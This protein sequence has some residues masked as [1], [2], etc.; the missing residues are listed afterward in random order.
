MQSFASIREIDVDLLKLIIKRERKAAL[1]AHWSAR[2][3]EKEKE[4]KNMQIFQKFLLY[5][6]IFQVSCSKCPVPS[7]DIKHG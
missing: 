7:M 1:S 2:E 6:E 5:F 3:K 4:N